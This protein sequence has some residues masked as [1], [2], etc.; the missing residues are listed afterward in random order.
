MQNQETPL[1]SGV[2]W[3]Q[4]EETQKARLR[5]EI[6]LYPAEKLLNTSVEDLSSYFYEKFKLEVPVLDRSRAEADSRE[7]Q[8]NPRHPRSEFYGDYGP[9][10]V[11]GTEFTLDIPYEGEKVF[12][13]IRPSTSSLSP[14]QAAVGDTVLTIRLR[15]HQFDSA[16]MKREVDRTVEGIESALTTLRNDA[17]PF[18]SELQGNA[19]A[20]IEA[21]RD[22]LLQTRAGAASMGFKMRERSGPNTYPA[23]EVRRKIAPTPP[24]ASSAPYT[25]EP[26]L[27]LTHYNH[28]LDVLDNMALVMERSPRDFKTLNEEALRTHFVMQLNGHYEGAA[29]GETFNYEGKTDILVRVDGKNIFIGECKFWAGAKVFAETLDQILGYSSWRDTK[30]AVLIFNRNKDFTK[31]LELIQQEAKAH[32]H[33]KKELG[34]RSETSFQYLFAHKDDRNREMIITVMVFDVPK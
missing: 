33:F 32:S 13:S 8:M 9:Q 1:F 19:R 24:K 31:V 10:H 11:T 28:I 29:T 27:E 26:V 12:F 22:K 15:T 7:V 20:L 3:H 34:N 2:M 25:P 5:E 14:P 21:R 18:N 23:P 30:V 17:A 16:E 4:V 6:S